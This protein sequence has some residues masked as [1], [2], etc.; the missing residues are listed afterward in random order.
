MGLPLGQTFANIFMCF[1]ERVWLQS[2]P[3]AFKPVLYQRY[4]DDTFLF[5]R[6]KE[7]AELFL[8]Y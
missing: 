5:F 1:H 6:R 8:N 3:D 7:H 2:C 4:I